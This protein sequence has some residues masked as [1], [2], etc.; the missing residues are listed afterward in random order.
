MHIKVYFKFTGIR[1]G[2][3]LKPI[4]PIEYDSDDDMKSID[5]SE[6][7]PLRQG[8]KDDDEDNNDFNKFGRFQVYNKSSKY[9]NNSNS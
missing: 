4:V 6:S 9:L 8:L 3:N 1:L 2:M 7:A 5:S